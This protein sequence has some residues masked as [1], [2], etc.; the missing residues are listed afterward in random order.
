[1]RALFLLNLYQRDLG[2]SIYGRQVLKSL[3]Q[4][5]VNVLC[6]AT[7]Y[8]SVMDKVKINEQM[9]SMAIGP[10]CMQCRFEAKMFMVVLNPMGY[11]SR[12]TKV[13]KY[14]AMV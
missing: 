12:L 9:N 14:I 4:D 5:T 13:P 2:H 6:T 7:M 8:I 11:Q 10:Y 3:V 1:M